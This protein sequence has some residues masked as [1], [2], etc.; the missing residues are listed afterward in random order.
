MNRRSF[1]RGLFAAAPAIVAAPSL[2]KISSAIFTPKLWGDGIHDDTVALQ[3][4]IDAAVP[5]GK[6]LIPA[7]EYLISRA[8]KFTGTGYQVDALGSNIIAAP[9]LA[10]PMVA[11]AATDI[12]LNGLSLDAT[13]SKFVPHMIYFGE[14]K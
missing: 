10:E 12:S 7:G 5:S 8:I 13:K 6:V 2:M 14:A 9:T 4:L 1:L 3:Q 11:L